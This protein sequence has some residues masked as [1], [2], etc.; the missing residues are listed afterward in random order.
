MF[1]FQKALRL[2]LNS[3]EKFA[4]QRLKLEIDKIIKQNLQTF[5]EQNV[6]LESIDVSLYFKYDKLSHDFFEE[7]S[8][9][10][11]LSLDFW[12]EYKKYSMLRNYKIDYNKIFKL[13]DKI[14][15]TGETC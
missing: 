5:S 4:S 6:T 13:T 9:E 8:K 10:I 15:T 14:K 3:L 7:I 1:I 11:D 12:R 2:K